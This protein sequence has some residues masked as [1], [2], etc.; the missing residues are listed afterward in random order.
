MSELGSH[1]GVLRREVTFWILKRSF[2]VSH[3]ES[4]GEQAGQTRE[5][6]QE[7]SAI[8]YYKMTSNGGLYQDSS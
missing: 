5:N 2:R 4:I 3:R 1:G 8:M 6:I 7:A